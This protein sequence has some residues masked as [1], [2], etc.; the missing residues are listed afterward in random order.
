VVL[1][2]SKIHPRRYLLMIGVLPNHEARRDRLRHALR[3]SILAASDP[4]TNARTA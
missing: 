1:N 2:V 3:R 4:S